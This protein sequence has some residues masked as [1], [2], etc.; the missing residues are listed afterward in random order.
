MRSWI[1]R[2]SL[3]AFA[4]RYGYD[5]SYLETMLNY[6][7]AALFKFA[8]V[9]K[10]SAHREV[11]PI[12]ASFAAKIVGALAEDCG[13]CTQLV[14]DMAL[15]AGMPRD[16]IEAVLRRDPQAMNEATTLGFRFAEAVVRKAPEDDEF[17]DAVRAQW[18]QK[19]VIDLTMALQLGRMFPMLKAG[20][21]YAKECRRVTVDGHDV[22][23]IKQAA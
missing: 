1:A 7:P 22:D 9:M 23:V 12:D 17:R 18:G 16:Q 5:V 3:R 20:L 21:G 2:R 14:V 8:P 11:A 13:P 19:G 10:A 4:R 6:S 15:E